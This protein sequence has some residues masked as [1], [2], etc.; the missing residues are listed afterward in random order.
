MI[1]MFI[2][3]ARVTLVKSNAYNKQCD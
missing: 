1:L 3:I 2:G